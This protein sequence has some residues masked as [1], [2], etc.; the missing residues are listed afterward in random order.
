MRALLWFVML[1]N[2]LAAIVRFH[3]L[4]GA[5]PRTMT[6]SQGEDTLITAEALAVTV[7]VA[8]LLFR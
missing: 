3:H 7:W 6:Y 2:A 8:Y 1:S 4:S 5:Y